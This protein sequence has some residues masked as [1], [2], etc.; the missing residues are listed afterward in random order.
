MAGD[1]LVGLYAEAFK[2][3]EQR[4]SASGRRPAPRPRHGCT[5][6]DAGVLMR[7]RVGGGARRWSCRLADSLPRDHDLR[8]A[9]VADGS[10]RGILAAAR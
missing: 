9:F 4:S 2:P 1:L 3:S 10:V 7:K 6:G 5:T 8:R